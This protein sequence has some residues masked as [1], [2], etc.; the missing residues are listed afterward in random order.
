[1]ARN[2]F[3]PLVVGEFFD[4]NP[5]DVNGDPVEPGE[6]F[7]DTSNR[8]FI[9]DENGGVHLIAM[10]DDEW[11]AYQFHGVVNE[12][13]KMIIHGETTASNQEVI[14]PVRECNVSIDWGDG[15][16]LEEFVGDDPSHI[17]DTAGDYTIKIHGISLVYGWP[18]PEYVNFFKGMESF[19]NMGII[20][21][22]YAFS[23]MSGDFDVPSM[24]PR[25]IRDVKFMFSD[26][27]DFNGDIS[28]WDMRKIIDA[29]NM[30]NN[31]SSFNNDISSWDTS[32]IKDMGFMFNNASSF[33][34]DIGGWNT[35]E[36]LNMKWMFSGASS[37]NQD[38]SDWETG[39]VMNMDRM[40]ANASLFNQNLGNWDIEKTD[41]MFNMFF[42]TSLSTLNYSNMLI[43]WSN[44]NVMNNV[45]FGAGNTTYNS[46][47][48]SARNILESTYNWDISDGGQD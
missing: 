45:I 9:K 46:S 13:D 8:L 29:S 23:G 12:W 39:N 28:G 25:T 6:L 40:F 16:P 38:I 2:I 32:G 21:A 4:N 34:K 27:P 37:F 5:L 43:S 19:G 36:V 48:T 20:S 22:A 7:M 18:I 31:A 24:L 14:I 15:T 17:Y 26:S 42:N 41:K 3:I 35:E 44:Q 11:S 47:A 30:F 10:S 33:D 1:M